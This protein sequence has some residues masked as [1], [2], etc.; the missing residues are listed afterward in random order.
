MHFRVS[1]TQNALDVARG[2]VAELNPNHFRGSAQEQRKIVEVAVLAH[3]RQLV[4]G[5]VLPDNRI[6]RGVKTDAPDVGGVGPEIRKRAA[7][8]R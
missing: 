2:T 8:S 4:L 3:D 6:V 5:R 7:E 1:R